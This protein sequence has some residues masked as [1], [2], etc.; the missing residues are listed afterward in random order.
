MEKT[1]AVSPALK[2]LGDEMPTSGV[3]KAAILMVALGDERA[4]DIYRQLGER[5]IERLTQEIA[6]LRSVPPA[7]SEAVLE[8][9]HELMETQQFLSFGG[10]EYAEKILV[11]TFGVV[12]AQEL[13]SQVK[14]SREAADSN[15]A[16]LQKLDMQQVAKF[17]EEEHPQTAALVLAHLN[18]RASSQA[19]A[20]LPEA[21][22]V[23]VV[24]RLAEMRQFSDEMAQK[25][26]LILRRRMEST[27]RDRSQ[28]Y[29]GF[30]VVADLLNRMDASATKQILESIEQENTEMALSIRNLMFTFEDF[31][32]VP[33]SSMMELVSHIDKGLLA[34]ALKGAKENL[35]MHFFG[36]LSSRA[37]EML[38]DDME[39][40]GPIRGR[41]IYKAQTE[42]LNVARNLE[43]SGK[44]M[45]KPEAED[46]YVA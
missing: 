23:S 32:T 28:S 42:I 33:A 19:L 38:R 46:E 39:V 2:D 16:P 21:M 17:L 43:A 14:R 44:L 35:R 26:G 29:S 41:D 7:V 20:A 31:V 37:V 15:L 18:P 6:I 5:E 45:L 30:K 27:G 36:A 24:K 22:R 13:L 1:Q 3:R 9:F 40:L 25:V 12:R 4:K 8:E 34:T 10:L 11:E